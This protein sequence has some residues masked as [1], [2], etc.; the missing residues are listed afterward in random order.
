MTSSAATASAPPAGVARQEPL[1]RYTSL[2]IG[3]PAAYFA[4]PRSP[5]ELA[6][7]LRWA[8]AAD[9]PARTIG[10]G[11]N[12][13]VADDGFRGL[14]VKPA[15]ARWH[16]EAGQTGATVLVAEAGAPLGNVARALGKRGLGGLEWA[17]TV[18]GTVGG[19][20]VNNAGAFGGDTAGC[21]RAVWLVDPSGSERRVG[22][23]ELEYGY[24]T[25]RLKRRELG[26]VAVSRAELALVETPAGDAAARIAAFQAQR[27]ASQPRRSSAGSVFANP[28]GAF[29]G[30]L[31]DEA[32]LKGLRQG[33]AQVSTQHAN[34]IVNLGRARA[35]D[36]YALV[37]LA[38]DAVL[39]RSGVWLRPEIELFGCWS[40]EQRR[41]LQ[42]LGDA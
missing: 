33:D 10:G 12:L 4:A 9:I 24:R 6:A 20:V 27:S 29:A 7:A 25:S 40:P 17:A 31:L 15:M 36:V 22:P 39:A 18:P 28:P 42:G 13:L 38:Q 5:A 14:V 41:G 3:G 1:A 16:V 2:K 32:G 23:D 37:R 30:Q 8:H 34:F 11:S 21:V 35:A 26:E 19:A